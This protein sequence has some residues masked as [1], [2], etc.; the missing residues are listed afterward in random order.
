M[1]TNETQLDSTKE[2]S[3]ENTTDIQTLQTGDTGFWLILGGMFIAAVLLWAVTAVIQRKR[4][5]DKSADASPE[6]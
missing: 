6:E 1:N 2:N 4:I 5:P 3:I